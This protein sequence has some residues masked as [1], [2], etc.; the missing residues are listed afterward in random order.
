MS[1]MMRALARALH[2]V[3]IKRELHILK[4]HL[5][6]LLQGLPGGQSNFLL[7]LHSLLD[8]PEGCGEK[9]KALRE[10]I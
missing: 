9:L 5:C 3:E 1:Q 2:A 8:V 6:L 7:Q 10:Y 4:C